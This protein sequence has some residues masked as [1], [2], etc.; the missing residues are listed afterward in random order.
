MDP[1][2]GKRVFLTAC[3]IVAATFLTPCGSVA[4]PVDDSV[5]RTDA[6]AAVESARSG[7]KDLLLF[8]TGSDWCPPCIKL[9]EQVLGTG[10]FA[11][12][13]NEKF[14][15][16]K[17][18]FPQNRELVPELAE[19]NRKWS[20]RFGIDAFPTIVLVDRDERPYAITGFRDEGPEAYLQHLTALL[21]ARIRRDD[22]FK[23]ADAAT[24]LDRAR[25]L[26]EGLSALDPNIVQVYYADKLDEI[27]VLDPDDAAGLRTKY[28]AQRDREMRQAVMN[29]IAMV[30]RLQKPEI[31]ITSIDQA[32]AQTKLPVD[33][34]LIAQQTKLRL[35]RKLDRV[36]EANE[37]VDQMA[38]RAD[39][40]PES[41]QRLINNKA[42]YLASLGRTD[43]AFALLEQE[44]RSQPANLLM[45]IAV[46]DLY[47]S[48]G[49]NEKAVA[50]YDRAI[51]AA[52]ARPEILLE[53]VEAKA[54]T[55]LEMGRSDDALGTLDTIS[56][57]VAIPAW[58][59]AQALLHKS[60]VLRESGRRRA[61]ILAENGAVE[62]VATQQE[63]A[64]LQNLIDQLRRKF[65]GE[66]TPESAADR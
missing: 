57:D 29:S 6:A 50:A 54:D 5:W 17:F 47:D 49:N 35:L 18:D 46:G 53:V 61:A 48:Q 56:E 58:L 21:D 10:E 39:V 40:D 7:G 25:F 62:L 8:Y 52:A 63:K 51:V 37:L 4:A 33:L 11:K 15:L 60:L 19:Q 2:W 64:A 31:A 45:T 1:C 22:A 38:D 36:D 32:M 13:A 26:D 12:A 34:W 43:D 41:R 66:S 65:D 20:D 9:E 14:V 55:L 16:V 3:G 28:F 44:I 23:K 27:D 30:A 42:Y 59:R 24:G